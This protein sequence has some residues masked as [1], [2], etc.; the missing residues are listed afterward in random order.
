MTTASEVGDARPDECG[1]SDK[2]K[3]QDDCQERCHDEHHDQRPE[4]VQVEVQVAIV[5]R[6]LLRRPVNGAAERNAA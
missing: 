4:D 5:F 2:T 6:V 3:R 1:N